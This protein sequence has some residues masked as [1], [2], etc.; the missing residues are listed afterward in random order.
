MDD[1]VDGGAGERQRRHDPLRDDELG[2]QLDR[3]A[4]LRCGSSPFALAVTPGTKVK[5]PTVSAGEKPAVGRPARCWFL[6][7]VISNPGAGTMPSAWMFMSAPGSS[8][9]CCVIEVDGATRPARNS[10]RTC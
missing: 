10:R 7:W 3:L 5:S 9:P 8:K 4:A 2:L 6:R 1:V